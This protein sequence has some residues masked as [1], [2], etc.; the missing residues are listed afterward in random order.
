[1][2]GYIDD[3][4]DIV[5]DIGEEELE[6]TVFEF[7]PL[8]V[9]IHFDVI[10]VEYFQVV[11]LLHDVAEEEFRPLPNQV[12]IKVIGIQVDLLLL[13][14]ILLDKLIIDAFLPLNLLMLV[15]ALTLINPVTSH[16]LGNGNSEDGRNAGFFLGL[17]VFL[18]IYKVDIL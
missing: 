14:L 16:S 2:H 17:F 6:V 7:P 10:E 8:I 18:I 12:P 9:E 5:D 11:V 13:S 3:H 4:E 15:L 1:M